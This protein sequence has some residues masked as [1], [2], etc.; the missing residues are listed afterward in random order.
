MFDRLWNGAAYRSTVDGGTTV[1]H[2]IINNTLLPIGT[3]TQPHTPDQLHL[4]RV[5]FSS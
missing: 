2:R 5:F 4:I 3:H 1:W